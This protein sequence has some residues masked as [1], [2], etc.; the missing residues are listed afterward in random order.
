MASI[1]MLAAGVAHEINNPLAALLMN[2]QFAQREALRLAAGPDAD[3]HELPELVDEMRVAAERVRTIVRDLRTFAH[4]ES[5][6]EDDP[7]AR[8]A[9]ERVLEMT[10]R[11]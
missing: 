8:V 6:S 9:V 3:A 1:G 10:A 7:G 5:G 2:L 11:M 4:G